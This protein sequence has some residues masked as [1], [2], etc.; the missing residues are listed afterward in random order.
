MNTEERLIS[1]D[2]NLPKLTN[3]QIVPN[4]SHISNLQAAL[5]TK[6]QM[7]SCPFCKCQ[8]FTKVEYQCSKVNLIFCIFTLGII[9]AP[10][11]FF[12]SKDFNCNNAKHSCMRCGQN[13]SEYKAC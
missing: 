12:R 9:W 1:E 2:K 5:K 7:V 8:D 11:Q 6:V 13:L 3:N 10:H 4:P